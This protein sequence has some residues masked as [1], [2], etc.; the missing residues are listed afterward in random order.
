[1]QWG[2]RGVRLP[3]TAL[4][5]LSTHTRTTSSRTCQSP[6]SLDR[7][8]RSSLCAR[9]LAG[10]RAELHGLQAASGP[11]TA[12]GWGRMIPPRCTLPL[13]T[14]LPG[15]HRHGHPGLRPSSCGDATPR[16]CPDSER[17]A[18]V[19]QVHLKP[20]PLAGEGAWRGLGYLC[21]KDS[22]RLKVYQEVAV[23]KSIRPEAA[24]GVE[25]RGSRVCAGTS[26]R[27]RGKGWVQTAV[28]VKQCCEC[29]RRLRVALTNG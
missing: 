27:R 25:R 20:L 11:D 14:G 17:G 3:R 7:G 23:D 8:R 10:S 16:I 21:L 12:A 24:Q 4:P 6:A 19:P 28:M 9:P 18:L 15:A 22:I 13:R 26:R 1:M 29:V 2:R 5:P